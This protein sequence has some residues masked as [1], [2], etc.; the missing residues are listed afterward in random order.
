MGHDGGISFQS[1][2]KQQIVQ[3]P[4]LLCK[5]VFHQ[6]HIVGQGTEVAGFDLL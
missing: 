1:Q 6:K 2:I 4:R 3:I 5:G